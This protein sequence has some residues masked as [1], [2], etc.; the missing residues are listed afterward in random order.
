MRLLIALT[1]LT[2][3]SC[4]QK[5]SP[6]PTP[7]PA[8][9]QKL[10]PAPSIGFSQTS[11][12]SGLVDTDL[13]DHQKYV[14]QTGG[15]SSAVKKDREAHETA[16]RAQFFDAFNHEEACD[17]II[18]KGAGDQKPQ[19]T[20]QIMVDTHDTPGQKPAWVWVLNTTATNAYLA[21]A[22]EDTSA[23]AAKDICL[24]VVKAAGP[25]EAKTAQK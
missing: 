20:L 23:T 9:R 8:A 14:E 3:V 2:V 18:F 10:G 4:A 22:E 17:G 19:F 13:F 6:T 15:D 12:A 24:A 7:Q 5:P 16:L 1:L 11:N 21:E 25:A